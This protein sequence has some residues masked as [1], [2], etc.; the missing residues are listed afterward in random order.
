MTH[1]PPPTTTPPPIPISNRVSAPP[2][3]TM[4][5]YS[6]LPRSS[7]H[8][9]VKSIS[10]IESAANAQTTNNNHHEMNHEYMNTMQCNA[11]NE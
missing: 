6:T 5:H 11:V 7:E 10:D 8:R 3:T 9:R 1:L 2:L 4:G